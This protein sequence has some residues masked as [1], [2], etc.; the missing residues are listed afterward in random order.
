MEEKKNRVGKGGIIW[1]WKINGDA[2][3]LTDQPQD[4][5]ITRANKEQSALL[6]VT[7]QKKT[8]ICKNVKNYNIENIVNDGQVQIIASVAMVTFFQ[9]TSVSL[10]KKAITIP[11]P[12]KFDHR[13]SQSVSFL[14]AL[15]S[16]SL[17]NVNK[18]FRVHSMGGGSCDCQKT[19]SNCYNE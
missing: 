11:S 5:P 9:K 10:R 17:V 3:Q 1:R 12:Q 19:K 4:Q 2:D 8:E 13:L 14:V 6:K 7:K 15:Q 18:G 16:K